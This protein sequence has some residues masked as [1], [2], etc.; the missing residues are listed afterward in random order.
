MWL[1]SRY[2]GGDKVKILGPVYA[3]KIER[4]YSDNGARDEYI[5]KR[6]KIYPQRSV[7]KTEKVVYVKKRKQ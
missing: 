1:G 2:R 5:E 4:G 7:G 3:Q 6:D